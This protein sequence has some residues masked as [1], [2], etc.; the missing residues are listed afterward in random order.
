[1]FYMKKKQQIVHIHGGMAFNSYEDY[2]RALENELEISWD[3]PKDQSRWSRDYYRVLSYD[4]Y[5]VMAPD[6]P[7]KN[8]AKYA[9]WKIWFEKLIPCLRDEVILVGHSLGGIFLAKYLSQNVL[10]V[11]IKQLHLVAPVFDHED[12]IEQLADFKIIEFPNQFFGNTI[13][14]VHLYHSIDDTI[15]PISESKKYHGQIPGSHLHIFEDRFHFIGETFP[16]LF[17][18]IKST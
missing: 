1:M 11:T 15:V 12:E 13:S 6:M 8:N 7:S 4:D 16:E 18:N 3:H 5:E 17:D 14:E 2:L 9:E 10:P